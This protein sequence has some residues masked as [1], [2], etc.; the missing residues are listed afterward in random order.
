MQYQNQVFDLHP[1]INGAIAWI[2]RDF[3]VRPGWDGGN[4]TPQP[5][6]NQKGVA[7][8]N[9]KPKPVFDVLARI[10]KN[11]Q[12]ANV[13]RAKAADARLHTSHTVSR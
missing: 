3:K 4:P 5:P 12:Q 10:Y 6:Y 9:G 11:V 1:F 2:L 7:D 8:Q 13:A